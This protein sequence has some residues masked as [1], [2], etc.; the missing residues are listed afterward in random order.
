MQTIDNIAFKTSIAEDLQ[1]LLSI[2]AGLSEVSPE[3]VNRPLLGRL[4][5][6]SSRCEELLDAY[7]AQQNTQLESFKKNHSRHQGFFPG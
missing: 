2:S 6:E 5:L 7:G 1:D 4:N 3:E